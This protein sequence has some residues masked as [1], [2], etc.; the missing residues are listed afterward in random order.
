MKLTKVNPYQIDLM[1][2]PIDIDRYTGIRMLHRKIDEI[3]LTLNQVT[4]ELCEANE[5]REG[6]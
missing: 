2:I 3:I 5:I 6:K 1:D 4:K